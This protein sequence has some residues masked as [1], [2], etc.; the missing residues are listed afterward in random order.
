MR[1][2]DDDNIDYGNIANLTEEGKVDDIKK[3]PNVSG[4]IHNKG[5]LENEVNLRRP[6]DDSYCTII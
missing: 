3:F 6:K 4:I 2:E 5:Q 1:K